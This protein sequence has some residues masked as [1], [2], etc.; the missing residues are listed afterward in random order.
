MIS[1]QLILMLLGIIGDDY[2]GF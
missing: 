2:D 1:L